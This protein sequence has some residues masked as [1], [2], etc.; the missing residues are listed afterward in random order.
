MVRFTIENNVRR[1]LSVEEEAAFEAA[2]E[3]PYSSELI[4]VRQKRN[5]LLQ[6]TDF[7]GLSDVTMTDAMKTYRQELRDITNGIN[8]YDQAKSIVW[9]TKPG[10]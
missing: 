3:N 8:N 9:P 6:E 4:N 7:Y 10:A 5:N 1:Q 2:L